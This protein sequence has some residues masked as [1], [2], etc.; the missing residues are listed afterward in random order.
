MSIIRSEVVVDEE[1]WEIKKLWTSPADNK[2]GWSESDDSWWII[3]RRLNDVDQGSVTDNQWITIPFDEV[4][5]GGGLI[6]FKY[7]GS[8]A[9]TIA[10]ATDGTNKL[11]QH[12]E[13]PESVYNELKEIG[14]W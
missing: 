10:Y 4:R 6:H 14:P 1:R 13:L 7:E 11:K 5:A 2:I 8:R 12:S 9:S 3:R